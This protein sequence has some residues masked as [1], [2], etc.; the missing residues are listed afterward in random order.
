[1]SYLALIAFELIDMD[2]NCRACFGFEGFLHNRN[3]AFIRY[4]TRIFAHVSI[5][6]VT[7][8]FFN[9]AKFRKIEYAIIGWEEIT[10]LKESLLNFLLSKKV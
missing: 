1:M 5:Y 7:A 3:W 4:V 9:V 6:R 10:W 2:K 8:L